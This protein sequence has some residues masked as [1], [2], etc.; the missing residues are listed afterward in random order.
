MSLYCPDVPTKEGAELSELPTCSILGNPL[1]YIESHNNSLFPSCR[2]LERLF[3]D[4]LYL[5][6]TC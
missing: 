5:L 3:L 6:N 2:R 1:D 4:V